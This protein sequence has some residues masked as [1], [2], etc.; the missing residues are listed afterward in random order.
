MQLLRTGELSSRFEQH[1]E[2]AT[3]VDIA[4]A[5]VTSCDAVAALIESATDTKVRIAVGLSGN[6]TE[7]SAL[8]S[9]AGAQGVKLRIVEPPSN[10]IFHWKYYCFRRD[11]EARCWVGS[12]NLTRAGF[13]CNEEVVHEF[14]AGQAETRQWFEDLWRTLDRDPAEAIQNYCKDYEPPARGTSVHTSPADEPHLPEPEFARWHW[15]DFV[16]GLRARDEYCH[17]ARH[18]RPF[19]RHVFGGKTPWDVFGETKSYLHTIAVGRSVTRRRDWRHLS[20]WDSNILL[21]RNDDQGVWGL[22][23]NMTGAGRVMHAF[24]HERNG[25]RDVIRIRARIRAQLEHVIEA[26][27][28]E[29]VERAQDAVRNIMKIR[30][31]SYGTATRLLCLARPDRLVSV[32]T[33][34][35]SHI[36]K[37][38]GRT[39]AIRDEARFADRYAEFLRWLYGQAWFNQEPATGVE[40]EIWSCRAALLDAYFYAGLNDNV[41]RQRR[42]SC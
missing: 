9:L 39:L 23:G 2:W 33:E 16:H 42:G 26:R 7:P 10:G 32:N 4:V 30:G 1:L 40:L 11:D 28:D 5:W 41:P 8:K 27:D 34:S 24:N 37:Y 18:R 19:P 31:F 12:A 13:H 3:E 6:A 35:E 17:H 20:S 38:F 36:K 22:L 29:V 25:E 21:G 14:D 15:S